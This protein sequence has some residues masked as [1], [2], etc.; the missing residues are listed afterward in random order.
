MEGGRGPHCKGDGHGDPRG[1][2]LAQPHHALRGL[3]RTTSSV[4]AGGALLSA[5]ASPALGAANPSLSAP[6]RQ[7]SHP[8]LQPA[9]QL[10][11]VHPASG[12]PLGRSQIGASSPS[13]TAR[14]EVATGLT[15]ASGLGRQQSNSSSSG[16]GSARAAAE[17]SGATER[18]AAE[19][20]GATE[21][22]GAGRR[23]L[24]P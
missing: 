12:A 8:T 14:P 3:Q 16:G 20:S 13:Q 2:S 19:H 11:S 17:P 9:S 5:G 7:A 18:A 24:H 21:R 23:T 1:S 4:S 10:H 6:R 15:V 22:A